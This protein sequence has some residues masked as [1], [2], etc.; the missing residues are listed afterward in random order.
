MHD[1][2]YPCIVNKKNNLTRGLNLQTP[3]GACN[4][5]N[6]Y[7]PYKASLCKGYSFAIPERDAKLRFARKG[8]SQAIPDRVV[9]N[10]AYSLDSVHKGM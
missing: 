9:K 8:Y 7:N 1:S 3:S 5:Y 2:F 10:I 6:P 4:P